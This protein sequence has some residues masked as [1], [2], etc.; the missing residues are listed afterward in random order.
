MAAEDFR[1][2][3]MG[4]GNPLLDISVHVDDEYLKKYSL[5][6][7][8]AILADASHATIYTEIVAKNPV[9][10]AGGASQNAIRGAQWLLPPKSTIYVGCVGKD[11]AAQILR[12]VAAKDGL[13]TDY[14]VDES[15]PTGRCAVLITGI[16]RSMVT[17]LQ[18]ANNYKITHAQ[19]APIQAYIN[20]AKVFY[21]EGYHLTVSPDTMLY[22]A[23]NA[24]ETGK[25]FCL[26]LSAPFIA[27][28][29]TKAL[30]DVVAYTDFLFG[31]EA[32]AEAFATAQN[33]GTTDV[34]EIALRASQIPHLGGRSRVVV[35]TQGAEP[36]IIAKDGVV[37]EYSIIPIAV[38][39][40]VDT[41]AAGDAFCG[42]FLSQLVQGKPIVECVAAGNY[43]AN[44]V[45][46][47]V[48]PTYPN[49]PHSYV[50]KA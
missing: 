4:F 43:V 35:F 48:G 44:V 19:S 25:T 38:S 47:R 37:T 14:L 22:V 20:S 42:G 17:D 7:N 6:A 34:K 45:I 15:A 1:P 2:I 40:I 11:D 26:N 29:F 5:K 3:L 13:R 49:V 9:Y 16:N 31:N 12:D 24:S 21:I 10:V 32:E 30:L 23:K 36:V 41:N 27:Q 28:F 50:F 39:S 18:A 8:D 46:Q 33:Y